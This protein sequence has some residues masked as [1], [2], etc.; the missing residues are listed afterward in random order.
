MDGHGMR[1]L[2]SRLFSFYPL[3]FVHTHFTTFFAAFGSL[4]YHFFKKRHNLSFGYF[5]GY[6]QCFSELASEYGRKRADFILALYCT[7][8]FL[9]VMFSYAPD[10]CFGRARLFSA[11][12]MNKTQD[13][14]R[15]GKVLF[16][17]E[18][19]YNSPKQ[20]VSR[21]SRALLLPSTSGL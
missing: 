3:E 2:F 4:L 8:H 6:R 12:R 5:P 17:A 21:V 11:D 10:L 7:G 14:G 18:L 19:C 16:L 15:R 20:N 13:P 9:T 1:P